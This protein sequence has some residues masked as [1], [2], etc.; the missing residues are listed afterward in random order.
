MLVVNPFF[1]RI[2]HLVDEQGTTPSLHCHKSCACFEKTVARPVFLR[3][4]VCASKKKGEHPPRLGASQSPRSERE[5]R[6]PGR[7]ARVKTNTH[8]HS[9]APVWHTVGLPAHGV[10]PNVTENPTF[11]FLGRRYFP[12]ESSSSCPATLSSRNSWSS[13]LDQGH[14]SGMSIFIIMRIW[15]RGIAGAELVSM[16]TMNCQ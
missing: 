11:H 3:T 10:P 15:P 5:R 14:P 16:P 12:P 7:A 13:S 6:A 4:R 2:F 9:S 1:H 8:W